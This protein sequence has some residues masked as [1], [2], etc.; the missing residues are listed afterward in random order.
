MIKRKTTWISICAILL[1]SV[2]SPIQSLAEHFPHEVESIDKDEMDEGIEIYEATIVASTNESVPLYQKKTNTSEVLTYLENSETVSVIE[3]D[4]DFSLVVYLDKNSKNTVLKGYINNNNL[5]N[6]EPDTKKNLDGDIDPNNEV[7]KNKEALETEDQSNINELST[8][9]TDESS[10][11]NSTILKEYNEKESN[12]ISNESFKEVDEKKNTISINSITSKSSQTSYRG[13]ALIDKTNVYSEASTE[14]KILKSYSKG[15]ILKYS[16]FT[17]DWYITAVYINGKRTTGYIHKSHVENSTLN[18]KRLSGIGTQSPTHVFSKASIS[19]KKLK[20]YTQGS[21]LKYRTFSKEWYEATV[22]ING[23]P[24]VGYIH[25]SHV[26]NS[27]TNQEKLSGIG[28]LNPTHVFAKASTNSKKLKSYSEG[29]ILK[30]RTFTKDWYIT[31]VYINGKKITGYIHRSHVSDIF[32]ERKL[33]EGRATKKP[34][35]VYSLASRKSKPLK[36]YGLGSLLKYRTF[37]KDWYI[38]TVYINGKPHTGYIHVDDVGEKNLVVNTKYDYTFKSLV[39]RQMGQSPKSDGAGRIPAT[40]GEVEFYANP[41]NFTPGTA[42]YLQ[43][44]V[45]SQPIGLSAYELN[46]LLLKE[47]GVLSGTGDAFVEASRKYQIN[48]VYLVAH[49]LH[50]TGNGKS[51]LSTGI[52]VDKNGKVTRNSRGEVAKTEDTAHFVYNMYGYGAYDSCPID[53]GA[54][55]AFDKKWFTLADS[56]VGGAESIF[57]Y[58]NRGQN[59]LYKMRWNPDPN[60]PDYLQYATHVQW[61]VLQTNNMAKIYESLNKYSGAFDVPTFNQLPDYKKGAAATTQAS[62]LNFRNGPGTG[63]NIIGSLSKGSKI[64]IIG[65][66]PNGWYKIDY[67]GKVG[68]VS[69]TYVHLD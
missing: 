18:Q 3:E 20:S 54:K 32:P 57:S 45:L 8:S 4:V 10:N 60:I 23:S 34:T 56:I 16:A 64:K 50:E 49:A 28:T 58:I 53:C 55:Y 61:A 17:S 15:S 22:Y 19:S 65:A 48:E 1:F 24:K 2:L 5:M 35:H 25:K 6:T 38:A 33:L 62:S 63:Y 67:N 31:G 52:P 21:V 43:F 13:I 26:E 27:T 9:T 51:G 59:T 39:D 42:S 69:A 46:E 40:R 30:Y 66:N 68:W 37:S 47:A 44:L 11:S 36:S 12:K 7:T 29:S 14:S 41:L